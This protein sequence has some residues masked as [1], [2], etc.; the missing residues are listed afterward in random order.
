MTKG[1]QEE[2]ETIEILVNSNAKTGRTDA[3]IIAFT[4]L[5]KQARRIF[6]YL[7]YQY[8][9]FNLSHYKEILAVIASKRFLDFD[10]FIKGFDII[11]PKSFE[12]IIG[13]NLYTSFIKTD[14]P[15]I[16]NFRNKILHGQPT[17]ESLSSDDLKIEIDVLK[18]WCF[19]LAETMMTEIHYD[20][21]EWNSFRK[22]TVKDL[23][24]TYKMNISD[25]KELDIFIETKMK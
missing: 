11:Y 4:K 22:C 7:I 3:F 15:R 21:L 16:K 2:F 25:I 14:F 9:V 19:H 6:T 20:G 24:P 5:E 17:G 1:F 10:N 23:A 8:P 12:A 13:G 18:N